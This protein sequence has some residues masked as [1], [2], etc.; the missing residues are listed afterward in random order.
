MANKSNPIV[1]KF[2]KFIG[3]EFIRLTQSGV[4]R[5][6]F[7]LE[8]I[9]PEGKLVFGETTPIMN[10]ELYGETVEVIPE[11]L[12]T[13]WIEVDSILNATDNDMSDWI[14]KKICRKTSMA[15]YMG[16]GC[17]SYD[18]GFVDNVSIFLGATDK[19]MAV[20]RNDVPGSYMPF[21]LSGDWL[22]GWKLI[23]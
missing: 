2:R 6:I 4:T 22:K 8:D 19:V 9:T 10:W 5:Q 21:F 12:G 23:E 20:K 15:I 17:W 18:T 1:D 14:G 16:D 3:K 13:K 11:L 7:K